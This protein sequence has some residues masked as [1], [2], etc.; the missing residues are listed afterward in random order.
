MVVYVVYFFVELSNLD[1]A[2][3]N[4]LFEDAL[5]YLFG[6]ADFTQDLLGFI[7]VGDLALDT[8]PSDGEG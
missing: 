3:Q 6:F 1:F 4:C 2:A 8:L 5:D 7:V